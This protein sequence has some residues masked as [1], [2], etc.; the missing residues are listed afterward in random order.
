MTNGPNNFRRGK[1]MT[2]Q[3]HYCP[4]CGNEERAACG[5]M[6]NKEQTPRYTCTA[7][8]RRY[9]ANTALTDPKQA[10]IYQ[11]GGH[12]LKVVKPAPTLE[13]LSN[14]E[15]QRR[16]IKGLK[17]QLKS[18]SDEAVDTSKLRSLI[19]GLNEQEVNPP[20]WLVSHKRGKANFG[21]PTLFLSDLH[22]GETVYP[23]QINGI[24]KYNLTIAHDR[25]ARTFKQTVR[26]LRD[27][28]AEGQYDGIV[29]ALGGDML[30]GNIHDEIRETNEAN[31]LACVADLHDHMVAGI[32]LLANEFGRVFV[33]CVVGNHGRLD[34]K[35]RA[36]G[37]VRDNFEWI[38][39]HYLA[40]HFAN[41][42]RVTVV[43]SESLDYLYRIHNHTYLLTHGDQF[44]GGT[45]IAGPMTPWALGDH[46]KRKRQDAINQPY[47]TMIFGHW[48]QLFWG[49]GSFICNGSLKGY[50]EYAF[51]F[52]FSVQ[53]AMQAL[54]IT[55]PE[56]GITFQMPVLADESPVCAE[57]NWVSVMSGS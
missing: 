35:P 4:H 14:E 29:V 46:K 33:P 2:A 17:S 12:K 8:Q 19:Y 32:E 26:L 15:K 20:K 5:H 55:H 47:D 53:P 56:H 7:C 51:R 57:R 11:P 52:N 40:K 23:E 10:R 24:N 31:V 50:D 38:F 34:K 18:L 36:K 45:G 41:D 21:T 37:A 9:N 27:Y 28:L 43:V 13:Q 42:D 22:W 54:W 3:R 30:S 39:Y 1:F 25:L 16:E 49:N 44:R 6:Q 48:H